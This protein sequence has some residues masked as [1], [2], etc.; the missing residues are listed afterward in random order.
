MVKQSISLPRDYFYPAVTVI[1]CNIQR[2][3]M[4][5]KFR[6]G[7]GLQTAL[8]TNLLNSSTVF[9]DA[10]L[11]AP[12]FKQK[13]KQGGNTKSMHQKRV[14][15]YS[16]YF[17]TPFW[18]GVRYFLVRTSNRE[19]KY[20]GS[21]LSHCLFATPWSVLIVSQASQ[22]SRHISSSGLCA[23]ELWPV[24][25]QNCQVTVNSPHRAADCS[26]SLINEKRN[27]KTES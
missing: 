2:Q 23:H 5:W 10:I 26:S 16:W 25:T 15:C 22:P 8:W 20:T 21:T 3:Y 18:L 14:C 27:G 17:S 6:I 19:S 11:C 7:T 4:H 13:T 1:I 24:L 9:T 12:K